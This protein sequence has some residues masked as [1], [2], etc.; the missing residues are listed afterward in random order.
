MYSIPQDNTPVDTRYSK[1]SILNIYKQQASLTSEDDVQ[2]LFV[3]NWNPEQ[4]NGSTGRGWG[5]GPDARDAS[6]GPELCW[7]QTGEVKPMSLEEMSEAE[8]AVRIYHL[9][10]R[11]FA[12]CS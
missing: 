9:S 3:G 12:D 10:F 1:E 4:S 8:K 2:R 5:K 6:S 11:A 7:D